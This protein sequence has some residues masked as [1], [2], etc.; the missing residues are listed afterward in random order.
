[1]MMFLKKQRIK[2]TVVELLT[3]NSLYQHCRSG[4]VG[5]PRTPRPGRDVDV[6]KTDVG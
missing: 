3:Y 6:S 5:K 4:S 2:I 1:M